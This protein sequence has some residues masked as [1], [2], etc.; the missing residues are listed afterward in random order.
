ME[1]AGAGPLD[2]VAQI[3][4]FGRKEKTVCRTDRIDYAQIEQISPKTMSFADA[5]TKTQNVILMCLVSKFVSCLT[6]LARFAT[7]VCSAFIRNNRDN[8][9]RSSRFERSRLSDF[10]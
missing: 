2:A 8:R 1:Y 4:A 6:K 3:D 9:R 5:K 10:K 7:S